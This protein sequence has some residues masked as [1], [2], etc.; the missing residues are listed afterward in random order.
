MIWL[1]I[2]FA[3]VIV[4]L[5]LALYE[6]LSAPQREDMNWDEA[7]Q[8]QKDIRE[9]EGVEVYWVVGSKQTFRGHEMQ[10]RAL[11]ATNPDMALD[12]WQADMGNFWFIELVTT[13]ADKADQKILNS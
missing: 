8:Y 2:V 3:L 5:V 10:K 13:D 6:C 1:L 4:L 7:P 9:M 12:K 11:F